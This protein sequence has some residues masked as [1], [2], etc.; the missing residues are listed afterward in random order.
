MFECVIV[1]IA[2]GILCLVILFALFT[3]MRNV[4]AIEKR[5]EARK[6]GSDV[7]IEKGRR[8]R[9]KKKPPTSS[10]RIVKHEKPKAEPPR[11]NANDFNSLFSASRF[12]QTPP[13]VAQAEAKEKA[14][15]SRFEPPPVKESVIDIKPQDK[16]PKK[17]KKKPKKDTF[18]TF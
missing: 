5:L 12:I 7:D 2:I 18:I 17:K 9:P 11:T 4:S 1:T 6:K 10:N 16:A 15:I 14:P 3:F 8:D 13:P